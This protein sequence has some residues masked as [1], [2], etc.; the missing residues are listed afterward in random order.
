MYNH[1]AFDIMS[2][3]AF[4][5]PL[6]MQTELTHRSWVEDTFHALWEIS[7]LRMAFYYPATSWIIPLLSPKSSSWSF[8]RNFQH[9]VEK[10][11]KSLAATPSPTGLLG[12]MMDLKEELR[13]TPPELHVNLQTLM[14][15]GTETSAALLSSVTYF[16]LRSPEA[17]ETLQQ[18]LRTAFPTSGDISQN[19]LKQ[20]PYLRACIEEALRLQAPVP[21]GV[22]RAVPAGG[23][24]I[25]GEFLPEKV[26]HPF[27]DSTRCG[28]DKIIG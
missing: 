15:A 12:R 19:A 7:L 23:S 26:N 6:N 22:P 25:S 5:D 1:A 21:L 3:Y 24:V 20:L 27:K 2:D 28:T 16:L 4:D 11:N 8:H 13:L 17:M 18:E 10:V 14:V 9:S